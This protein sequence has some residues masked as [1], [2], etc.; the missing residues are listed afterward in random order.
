MDLILIACSHKKIDGGVPNYHESRLKNMLSP[1]H[2]NDLMTARSELANEFHLPLSLDLGSRSQFQNI[3]YLPSYQRYSGKVYEKSN[4]AAIF[5][6]VQEKAVIIVS[7]LYGL[8]DAHDSI[9][10]YDIEMRYTRHFWQLHS[11]GEIL[12]DY[13]LKLRPNRVHDLL[14]NQY[15]LSLKPFPITDRF[16]RFGINYIEYNYPGQGMGALWHRGNDLKELLLM[17]NA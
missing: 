1:L 15:R 8:L 7:A 12:E 3:F 4:F 5:P 16:E 2:Y 11:L 6:T 14:S 9:R 17:N 13:I 10:D